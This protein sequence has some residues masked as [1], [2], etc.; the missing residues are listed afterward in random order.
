MGAD[1]ETHRQALGGEKPKLE[2]SIVYLPL[3]LT[4]L[5][6]FG[7]RILGVREAKDTRRIWPNRHQ[8]SR[9]HKGSRTTIMKSPWVCTR[10]SACMLCGTPNTGNGVISNSFAY[11]WDHFPPIGLPS[12]SLIWGICLVIV[13]CYSMFCWYSLEACYFLKGNEGVW[14]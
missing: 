6:N 4:E 12:S 2:I 5:Q 8:L 1:A 13:S 11:S 10:F 14:I 3:E 9:A 7:A